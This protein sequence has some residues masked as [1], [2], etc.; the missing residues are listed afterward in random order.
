MPSPGISHHTE[1]DDPPTL[2]VW[3]PDGTV[4]SHMLPHTTS[5]EGVGALSWN[6]V[7]LQADPQGKHMA[8]L[9]ATTADDHRPELHEVQNADDVA[10]T[11]EDHVPALQ[12]M[13]PE[14]TGVPVAEAHVPALQAVHEAEP[15]LDHIPITQGV[16]AD[17]DTAPVTAK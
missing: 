16:H 3:T 9:V 10:P 12:K 5:V 6:C 7:E 14:A 17:I 8:A 2:M 15:G 11:T 4:A 1:N 13:H